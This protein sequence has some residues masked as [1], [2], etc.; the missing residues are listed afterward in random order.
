MQ[1]KRPAN[2]VVKQ[3]AKQQASRQISIKQAPDGMAV[4]ALV[5]DTDKIFKVWNKTA[6]NKPGK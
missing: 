1:V 3:K 4:M 6:G 5:K 2:K